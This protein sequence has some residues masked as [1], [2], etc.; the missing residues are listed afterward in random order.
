MESTLITFIN[1]TSNVFRLI[2]LHLFQ[3]SIYIKSGQI[4]VFYKNLVTFTKNWYISFKSDTLY[5]S[6]THIHQLSRGLR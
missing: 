1:N 6:E 5:I 2:I 4:K 3:V